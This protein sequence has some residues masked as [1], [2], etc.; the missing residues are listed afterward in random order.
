MGRPLFRKTKDGRIFEWKVEKDDPLCTLQEVFQKVDH[1]IGFNIELKFDNDI[2]YKEEEL[3][4]VLQV[5]LKVSSFVQSTLV[6]YFLFF[7]SI[8]PFLIYYFYVNQ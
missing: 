7:C 5:I 8:A 6:F 1:S 4:H 3:T 2:A